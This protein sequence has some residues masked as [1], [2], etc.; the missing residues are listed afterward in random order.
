MI[1]KQNV[2]A[3]EFNR[4]A[5]S[6][7]YEIDGLRFLAEGE[8]DENLQ[9]EMLDSMHIAELCLK[10]LLRWASTSAY[11]VDIDEHKIYKVKVRMTDSELY[12]SGVYAHSIEEL[13]A[14]GYTENYAERV[15]DDYIEWR[16]KQEERKRNIVKKW[17]EYS[18]AHVK[19]V[20]KHFAEEIG[21]NYSFVCEAIR[22][23]QR[24]I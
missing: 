7:Q 6:Y 1:I 23:S 17:I 14:A 10:N 12:H 4:L 24:E 18:Q 15:L 21:E 22:D 16:N 11:D 9:K 19:P 3:E 5:N 13:E 8:R 2:K 20:K